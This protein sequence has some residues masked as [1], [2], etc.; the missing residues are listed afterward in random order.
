[1]SKWDLV[2]FV[3]ASKPRLQVLVNLR[4]KVSTPTELTRKIGIPISR[5]SSIL[6]ELT[7]KELVECLTPDRRK[8]KIFKITDKGNE[9]IDLVDEIISED[10]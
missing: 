10:D 8:A 7:E 3:M 6:K 4:E 1:M 5:T 9:V 2:S